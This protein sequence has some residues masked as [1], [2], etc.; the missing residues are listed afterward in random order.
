MISIGIEPGLM[1]ASPARYEK[2]DI[3]SERV[4]FLSEMAIFLHLPNIRCVCATQVLCVYQGNAA[5]IALFTIP[6]IPRNILQTS[7]NAHATGSRPS[8]DHKNRRLRLH[9][10]LFFFISVVDVILSILRSNCS[11]GENSTRVNFLERLEGDVGTLFLFRN[12][13]YSRRKRHVIS[14]FLQILSRALV[15][16]EKILI[17]T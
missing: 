4:S 13:F 17:A 5:A 2:I 9:R 12:K 8:A 11:C 6:D 15:V 3:I 1:I 10:C 7:L 14:R 16:S